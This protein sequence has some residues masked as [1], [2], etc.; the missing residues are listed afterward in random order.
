MLNTK[1]NRTVY[2]S[3]IKYKKSHVM[4]VARIIRVS[5]YYGRSE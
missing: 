5:I 1:K 3:K 2:K 4:D